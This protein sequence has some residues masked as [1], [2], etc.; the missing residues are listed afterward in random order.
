MEV[1]NPIVTIVLN[2][3][4]AM[5]QLHS[6]VMMVVVLQIN[7]N[8]LRLLRASKGLSYA[9]MVSVL[10]L[11]LLAPRM[12]VVNQ[13]KLVAQMVL[14][15]I[16]CCSA[17]LS[18]PVLPLLQFYVGIILVHHMPRNARILSNVLLRLFLVLVERAPRY[19][20]SVQLSHVVLMH[21]R[22]C[23]PMVAVSLIHLFVLLHVMRR[24]HLELTVLLAVLLVRDTVVLMVRVAEPYS[25]IVLQ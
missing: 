8:V 16:T 13:I 15:R 2:N 14:A 11:H 23:V 18:Q 19:L 24:L 12:Q 6:V 20:V 1:V 9:Q 5:L 7:L 25:P 22:F 10:L 21:L 17:L 3:I 4:F